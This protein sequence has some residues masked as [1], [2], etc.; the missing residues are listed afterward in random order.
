MS[1]TI[2]SLRDLKFEQ[3]IMNYFHPVHPIGKSLIIHIPITPPLN[4]VYVTF[5]PHLWMIL[6]SSLIMIAVTHPKQYQDLWA[7]LALFSQMKE[8]MCF[9][10]IVSDLLIVHICQYLMRK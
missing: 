2:M 8:F 1:M 5:L 3:T 4:T 6:W 9:K 7:K 10:P